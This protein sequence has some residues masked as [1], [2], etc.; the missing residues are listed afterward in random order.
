MKN[1]SS[2]EIFFGKLKECK[3]GLFLFD[4]DGTLAPFTENRS[5]AYPYQGICE[6]LS[7]LISFSFCRVVIISGR[8]LEDLKLLLKGL[9]PLPELWGSHGLERLTLQGEYWCEKID[10]L[11]RKKLEEA[12][13][14]CLSWA[15]PKYC[16]IKPLAVA[17]HWRGME[18]NLKIRLKNSIEKEWEALCEDSPLEVSPFD[19]GLEIRLKGKN[20]G[21]VIKE[22]LKT[23]GKDAAIVYLGDDLTDESAFSALGDKGLKILVRKD[24]RDTL[25]DV[26]L[27]PPD[28]LFVFLDTCIKICEEK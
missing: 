22:L 25:A 16:E 13:Q 27:K 10:P 21:D 18:E 28:E 26:C 6:R 14:I 12:K 8:Q 1:I 24:P 2:L 3:E 5:E 15:D 23:A 4:Y 7:G 9:D 17:F 19:G 20:K 11:A